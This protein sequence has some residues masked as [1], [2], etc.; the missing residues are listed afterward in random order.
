[1]R[2]KFNTIFPVSIL[3][4]IALACNFNYSTA[5]LSEITFGKNENAEPASK[6]FK[7]GDEIFAVSSVN[8]ASGKNKVRFRLLFDD[9]EGAET[10]TVAYKLEKEFE[11]EGSK[12]F[13]YT[14]SVPGGFVPGE[15]K[16]EYV[17]L[18]EDGEKDFDKKTATFTISGDKSADDKNE[19]KYSNDAEDEKSEDQ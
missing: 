12:K 6:T 2:S 15:Y 10:D 17:L 18:N 14:F 16:V 1:M 8:N 7:P 13:W 5:N 11:I 19:D 9:V 4:L 3:L